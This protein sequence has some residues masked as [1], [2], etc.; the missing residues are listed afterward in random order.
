MYS[1]CILTREAGDRGLSLGLLTVPVPVPVP[2]PV[3]DC[4][5]VSFG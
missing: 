1:C 2:L 5:K 4:C 3:P